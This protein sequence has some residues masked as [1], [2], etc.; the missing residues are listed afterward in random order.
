MALI[1]L[2]YVFEC[3]GRLHVILITILLL[4]S[5]DYNITH[6]YTMHTVTVQPCSSISRMHE[7]VLYLHG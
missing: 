2:N 5:L 3:P 4:K 6:V 1:K 7:G